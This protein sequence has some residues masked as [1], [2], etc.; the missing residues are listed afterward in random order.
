MSVDEFRL[1]AHEYERMPWGDIRNVAFEMQFAE[2]AACWINAH[3]RKG[4][5]PVKPQDLLKL[6]TKLAPI[7]QSYSEISSFVRAVNG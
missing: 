5:S 4:T 3:S 2:F 6:Q 1:W 7:E